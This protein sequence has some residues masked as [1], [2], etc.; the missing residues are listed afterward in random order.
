[1]KKFFTIGYEKTN[2]YVRMKSRNLSFVL[3]AL[4]LRLQTDETKKK[5]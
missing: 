4:M 5:G 2:E 3:N 1:M